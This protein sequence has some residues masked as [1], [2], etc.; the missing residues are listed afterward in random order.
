MTD[1]NLQLKV[2]IKYLYELNKLTQID[3]ECVVVDEGPTKDDWKCSWHELYFPKKGAERPKKCFIGE[4]QH[5][6]KRFEKE[7]NMKGEEK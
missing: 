4:I 2:A 7:M 3:G 5:F 6:L 1:I